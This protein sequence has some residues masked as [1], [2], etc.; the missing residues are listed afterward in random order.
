MANCK[1]CGRAVSPKASSCPN[2]GEPDPVKKSPSWAALFLSIPAMV[3]IV[4][5]INGKI[6]LGLIGLVVFVIL[7][8]MVSF[9]KKIFKK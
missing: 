9:V 6:F 7:Y 4:L 2:C 8:L 5:F 3:V 1:H